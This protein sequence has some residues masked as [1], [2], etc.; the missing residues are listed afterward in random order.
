MKTT[1][2]TFCL[3][4]YGIFAN[5]QAIDSTQ[6]G[7]ILYYEGKVE[8]GK[9]PNWVKVKIN[10]P[11][12]RNQYIRI[13][14]DGMAEIVWTS[15]SKTTVGPNSNIPVSVLHTGSTGKSKTETEG[16]FNDFK[17]M[18][19][20]STGTKSAQEGG[21]RR[22]EADTRAKQAPNEVYWKQDVEISFKEAFAFYE[23]QDYG[24]AIAALQA[25]I[26]QKPDDS[27]AVYAVF[28]LGHSYI[29]SNNPVKAKEIFDRF[30]IR[31][32]KDPLK[33]EADKVLEKL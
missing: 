12:K 30:V 18:F 10:M 20:A 2:F 5:A 24:K 14:G 28:A 19:T 7:K 33:L 3:I 29:M 11:V 31:Y 32:P 22:T 6:V 17:K 16:V 23:A 27:L 26:Y 9:D 8:V 13:P 25:F 1:I 21:I 15:G 4:V